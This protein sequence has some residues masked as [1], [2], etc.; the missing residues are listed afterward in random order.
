MPPKGSTLAP[1]KT[2]CDECPKTKEDKKI[3]EIK[4]PHEVIIDPEKCLLEQGI[5]CAGVA[6][7]AGCEAACPSVN[8]PCRG[9]MGPTDGVEDLG[10]KLLSAVASILNPV[11]E[12]IKEVIKR[13]PDPV[14]TFYRFSL[15]VGYINRKIMKEEE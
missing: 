9:C 11:G 10:A 15:P 5:L 13:I 3:K 6:T 1:T 12:D 2:V 8:M 14:G 4:R 7:R